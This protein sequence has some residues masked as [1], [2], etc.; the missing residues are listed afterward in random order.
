MTESQSLID[1]QELRYILE[2]AVQ[3]SKNQIVFISAYLSEPAIDWLV[4]YLPPEVDAYLICRL[5]PE[6]VLNGSTNIS[7]LLKALE[8][9]WNVYCLHSLHA[10]LYS[11]DNEHIFVGSANLTSNGLRIYGKGNVEACTKVPPNEENLNFISHITNSST[12]LNKDILNKMISFI[13]DQKLKIDMK[14]WPD[15]IIPNEEGIWVQ[16]LFWSNL[17]SNKPQEEE[18]NHDIEILG[19]NSLDP[20]IIELR[21]E[22]KAARCV[23]WLLKKLETQPTKELYFGTISQLLHN[24]LK[25]DPQPYRKDVKTLVQNLLIFCEIYLSGIVEISQPAHSQ[26][27][28]LLVTS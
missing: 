2:H 14:E 7:A 17:K 11:I 16:D 15:D 28:K 26:K 20:S 4:R 12:K 6:D 13:R 19:I 21:K 24:D 10:K 1:G 18:T 9:G 25:D 5:L 27:A 22:I 23:Q 8:H 3:K